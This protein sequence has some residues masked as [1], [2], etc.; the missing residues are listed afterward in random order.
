MQYDVRTPEEY[1]RVLE[2]DWRRDTLLA[3]RELIQQN[4]PELKETIEYKMLCYEDER[5]AVF[6]LNAQRGD[7]SLYVG[8]ADKVDPSGEL[9]GNL[10]RGKGCIRFKKSVKVPDTTIGA[11]I[12]RAAA[13]RRQGGDI[14]C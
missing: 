14:D 7:V 13:M 8:N 2:Q 4:A 1:L 6:A 11:F 12:S 3:L 10:D 9:L 5:G